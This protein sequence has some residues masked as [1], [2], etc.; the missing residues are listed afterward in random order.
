VFHCEPLAEQIELPRGQR[1]EALRGYVA[2]YARR[3][4]HY[5]RQ[6]PD[7]WFNFHDFWSAPSE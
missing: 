2:L 5:A 7:N 4:E 3:L 6:A 1:D